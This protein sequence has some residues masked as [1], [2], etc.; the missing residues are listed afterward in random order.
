V[1]RTA[2]ATD[3]VTQND[4]SAIPQ[5]LTAQDSTSWTVTA[6]AHAQQDQTSVKSY[7]AT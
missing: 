2:N 3:L 6:D 7:P 5:T 1:F 4:F